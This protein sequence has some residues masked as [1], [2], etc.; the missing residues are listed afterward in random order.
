MDDTRFQLIQRKKHKLVEL[1]L[2]VHRNLIELEDAIKQNA[3]CTD[4]KTQVLVPPLRSVTEA[5]VEQVR[6]FCSLL[7]VGLP[8]LSQTVLQCQSSELTGNT[9][10]ADSSTLIMN[11]TITQTIASTSKFYAQNRL[12]ASSTAITADGELASVMM[13]TMLMPTTINKATNESKNNNVS[14]YLTPERLCERLQ[15]Q[16]QLLL[17]DD[18][19][20]CQAP[21]FILASVI[22]HYVQLKR[23]IKLVAAAAAACS[24]DSIEQD[25]SAAGVQERVDELRRILNECVTVD[26]AN[27]DE[28][29]N[30]IHERNQMTKKQ[31]ADLDKVSTTSHHL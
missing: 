11:N 14:T 12:A 16:Q 5:I 6:S 26:K 10:C 24:A 20:R 3:K 9:T 7:T 27:M 15:Q 21:S 4:A 31:K 1:K 13:M 19:V 25:T 17:A 23:N 2:L 28:Y 18:R 30:Q 29:V 8:L 22:D